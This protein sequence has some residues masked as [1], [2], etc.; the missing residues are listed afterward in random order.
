MALS[1]CPDVCSHFRGQ[2]AAPALKVEKVRISLK[3]FTNFGRKSGS[4]LI[5]L[6][7]LLLLVFCRF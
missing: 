2:Q 4:S 3:C 7:L 6:L 5:F 1:D